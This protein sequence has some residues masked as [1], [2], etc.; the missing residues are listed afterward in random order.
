MDSLNSWDD[1]IQI[2]MAHPTRRRIIEC[3]RDDDLS[4]TD[5]LKSASAANHGN[6]GYHL[7]ALKGYVEIDPSTKKHRLTYRGRLLDACIRDF[8]FITSASKKTV[9]Y[10]KALEMG[11]H[12]FALYETEDFK[13]RIA[14][15]FLEAGLVRSEA[16]LYLVSEHKLDSE[17]REIQ[18]YGIDLDSLPKE[19]FTVMSAEEYYLRKG[20][21]QS[22]RI[23]GNF[24]NMLRKRQK[25]GFAKL[26]GAGEV[27]VFFENAKARELMRYEEASGRQSGPNACAL[28]LYDS[29]R[30]DLDQF[31]QVYSYHGH[32]VSKDMVGRTKDLLLREKIL[33]QWLRPSGEHP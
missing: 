12:A 14:F 5:L 1:E 6:F 26:R 4:F 11:D 28:C 3:L 24:E 31:I 25:V 29:S 2:A 18:R 8:R 30:L 22:E 16:I 7:R 27:D 9:E 21:A 33:R 17:I 20:K 19:A 23:L 32:I 15:P 10:A 13:R